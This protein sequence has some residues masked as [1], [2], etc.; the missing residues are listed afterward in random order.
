MTTTTNTTAV[1]I[2]ARCGMFN[3]RAH[4]FLSPL[5][6]RL[7]FLN[8]LQIFCRVWSTV[9][10]STDTSAIYIQ[11]EETH[12]FSNAVNFICPFKLSLQCRQILIGTWLMMLKRYEM[13]KQVPIGDID[14]TPSVIEP[15]GFI[16]GTKRHKV[17]R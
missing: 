16:V 10:T 11:G 13:H 4:S 8:C 1:I 3:R 17:H 9:A 12:S 6:F 5:G 15:S 14:S 7:L 2:T